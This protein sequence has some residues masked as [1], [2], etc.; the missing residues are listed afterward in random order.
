[1]SKLLEVY[2]DAT[3]KV[4]IMHSYFTNTLT[5]GHGPVRLRV[6]QEALSDSVVTL[7]GC[8]QLCRT[9]GCL[10]SDADF[11]VEISLENPDKIY[12][13][14]EVTVIW[15]EKGTGMAT[16]RF[17]IPVSKRFL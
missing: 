16:H 10:V 2:K 11:F 15:L 17:F 5:T 1:M 4:A 12:R 9:W 8:V 6:T 7:K 3:V 14:R 13:H